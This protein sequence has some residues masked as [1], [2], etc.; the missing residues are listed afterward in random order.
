[1]GVTLRDDWVALR[2]AVAVAV[3]D[4]V[5]VKDG[6]LHELVRSGVEDAVKLREALAGGRAVGVLVVDGGLGVSV[7]NVSVTLRWQG[8]SDRTRGAANLESVPTADTKRN[9]FGQQPGYAFR[10][11]NND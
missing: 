4:R 2:E 1:M 8:S 6:G 10:A 3:G 7:D 11:G 9:S 5:R